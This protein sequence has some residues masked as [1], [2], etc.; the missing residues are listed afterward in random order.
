MNDVFSMYICQVRPWCPAAENLIISIYIFCLYPFCL[1]S[2]V[3]GASDSFPLAI[4]YHHTLGVCN[5]QG[6]LGTVSVM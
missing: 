3:C 5:S 1:L 4:T 2:H 6:I